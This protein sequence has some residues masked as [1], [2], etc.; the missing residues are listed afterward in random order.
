VLLSGRPLGVCVLL[1]VIAVG[2]IIYHH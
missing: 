2:I 1:Y